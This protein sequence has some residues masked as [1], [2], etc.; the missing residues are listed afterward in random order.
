MVETRLGGCGEWPALAHTSPARGPRADRSPTV[1]LLPPPEQ[2]TR[3]SDRRCGTP[4]HPA[5]A[6]GPV[7]TQRRPWQA[8]EMRGPMAPAREVSAQ[9]GEV[10]PVASDQLSVGTDSRQD[11]GQEY[12]CSVPLRSLWSVV[13]TP[14]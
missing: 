6:R 11:Q 3:D 12:H 13:I 7:E 14:S 10:T 1:L 9:R 8:S 4:S 5:A 2:T